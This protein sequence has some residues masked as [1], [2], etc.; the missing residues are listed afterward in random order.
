MK[1]SKS[2]GENTQSLLPGTAEVQV[3]GWEHVNTHSF[4]P[5]TAQ[6]QVSHENTQPLLSGTADNYMRNIKQLFFVDL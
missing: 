3:R 6:V 2:L 5:G 1:A 4:L